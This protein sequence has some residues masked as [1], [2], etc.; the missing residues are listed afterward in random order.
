[1]DAIW[2]VVLM[3]GAGVCLAVS[4]GAVIGCLVAVV[5]MGARALGRLRNG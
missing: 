3:V 5:C 2:T 1:M 4:A